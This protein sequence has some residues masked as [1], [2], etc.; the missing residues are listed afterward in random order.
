[1]IKLFIRH[2]ARTKD[3]PYHFIDL[4]TIHGIVRIFNEP[5]IVI[6]D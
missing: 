6:I 1:M 4:L 3:A 2:K 5:I